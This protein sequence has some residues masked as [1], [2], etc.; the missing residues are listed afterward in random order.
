MENV[1]KYPSFMVSYLQPLYAAPK[2]TR[3]NHEKRHTKN[4]GILFS[5]Y[6][7]ISTKQLTTTLFKKQ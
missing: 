2:P 7:T 4:A 5:K 3:I 6:I 1:S